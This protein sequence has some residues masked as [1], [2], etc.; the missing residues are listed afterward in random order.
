MFILGKRRFKGSFRTEIVVME[1]EVE[2]RS[3]IMPITGQGVMSPDSPGEMLLAVRGIFTVGLNKHWNRL[4][5]EVVEFHTL[6][7]FERWL[8]R[9][10]G[11]TNLR[12][13]SQREAGLDDLH[14]SLVAWIILWF[15]VPLC[16]W[17]SSVQ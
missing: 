14:R 8:G 15:C 13:S 10:L 12:A 5:R 1:M 17:L 6:E 2:A 9:A 7:I 4:L 3:P 11:N 16:P